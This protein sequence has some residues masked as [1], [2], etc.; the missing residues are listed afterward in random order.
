MLAADVMAVLTGAAGN[1]VAYLL[2]GRA[3][4]VK[5]WLTRVL[6]AATGEERASSLRALDQDA[7]AVASGQAVESELQAKWLATLA[8]FLAQHPEARPEVEAL[9]AATSD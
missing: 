1:I 5:G 9:A 6:R 3:D 2:N 4:A 7:V 8:M